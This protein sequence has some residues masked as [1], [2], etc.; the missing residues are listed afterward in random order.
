[1]I[2]DDSES[3]QSNAKMDNEPFRRMRSLHVTHWTAYWSRE[4]LGYAAGMQLLAAGMQKISRATFHGAT[5]HI[6]PAT[7]LNLFFRS[8]SRHISSDLVRKWLNSNHLSRA[9]KWLNSYFNRLSNFS[10]MPRS[11]II[12][13][14]VC[15]KSCQKIWTVKPKIFVRVSEYFAKIHQSVTFMTAISRFAE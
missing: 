3:T 9:K 14:C 2:H 10:R 7:S 5:A 4:K 12:Y 1:M 15:K 6:R 13:L 8:F 11:E